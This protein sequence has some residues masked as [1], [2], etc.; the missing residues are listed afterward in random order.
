MNRSQLILIKSMEEAAEYIQ[1]ASKVLH[2]GPLDRHPDNVLN[3]QDHMSF[4]FVD[5]LAVAGM[6][7]E[8]GLLSPFVSQMISS[9]NSPEIN[10]LISKKRKKVEHYLNV[11]VANGVLK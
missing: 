9:I 4:E 10:M 3:N 6:A 11:S 7:A 1:A 2:F 8:E 5:F